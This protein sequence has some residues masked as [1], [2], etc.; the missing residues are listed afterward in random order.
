MSLPKNRREHSMYSNLQVD[1]GDLDLIAQDTVHT[2]AN[3]EALCLT[4][5]VLSPFCTNDRH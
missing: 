5:A 3:P 2:Q 1:P 4:K